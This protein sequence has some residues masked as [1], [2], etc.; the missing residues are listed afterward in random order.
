MNWLSFGQFFL[1]KIIF[2][3]GK[4]IDYSS[5]DSLNEILKLKLK[6]ES[7]LGIQAEDLISKTH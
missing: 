2:G 5:S 4:E 1:P 6:L 3:V 7:L